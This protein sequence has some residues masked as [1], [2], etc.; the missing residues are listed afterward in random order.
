MLGKLRQI[1]GLLRPEGHEGIVTPGTEHAQF[2][3][4]YGDLLV[5]TLRLQDGTWEFEYSPEFRDQSVVKPLVDFPAADKRYRAEELW[6]F[7]MARIPSL[8]QPK[9]RRAIEEEG[10]D[11]HSDVQLLRRFGQQT[12]ANP[13]V[14]S[15][16]H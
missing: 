1:L 7:F 9:V 2:L 3:L 4:R 16:S 6:P 15:E 14:L 13:F 12:I 10:L 8:A 11:A 5:G